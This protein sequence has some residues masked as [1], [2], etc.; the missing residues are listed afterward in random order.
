VQIVSLIICIAIQTS[1]I[2]QVKKWGCFARQKTLATDL[3]RL[4]A[5]VKKEKRR[6]A[7]FTPSHKG[8]KGKS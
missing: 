3:H 1:I 8:H 5:G 4:N 2:K 6:E 7:G